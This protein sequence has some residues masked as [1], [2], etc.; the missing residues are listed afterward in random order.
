MRI[1]A[2]MIVR[3]CLQR[4][5]KAGKKVKTSEI[6]SVQ[7]QDVGMFTEQFVAGIM[8]ERKRIGFV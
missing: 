4:V 3:N 5:A 6:I 8:K 7:K 1:V 2:D